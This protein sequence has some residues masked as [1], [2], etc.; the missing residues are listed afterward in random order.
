MTRGSFKPLEYDLSP[1]GATRV[2][3]KALF[4][5]EKNSTDVGSSQTVQVVGTQTGD[6]STEDEDGDQDWIRAKAKS[7]PW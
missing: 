2:E 3:D 4:A 1:Q 6:L 5:T 7:L